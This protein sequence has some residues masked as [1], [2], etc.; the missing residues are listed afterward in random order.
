MIAS[1]YNHGQT[2]L[3]VSMLVWD[4]GGTKR[5]IGNAVHDYNKDPIHFVFG[6]LFSANRRHGRRIS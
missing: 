1:K 3:E 2:V 5:S 6:L 4:C